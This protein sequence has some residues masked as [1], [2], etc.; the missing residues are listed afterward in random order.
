MAYTR[1]EAS[2]VK[3]E[4]WKKYGQF[5]APVPSADWE[6]PKV[7]WI[8]YKT[9]IKSIHFK[10]N[11]DKRTASIG[12]YIISDEDTQL[13]IYTLMDKFLQKESDFEDWEWEIQEHD[14][15]FGT[16][17]KFWIEIDDV[18][19][20]MPEKWPKLISF[21]KENMIKLDAFWSNYKFA[22]DEF[23]YR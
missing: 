18:N 23:K 20:F 14:N 11:A 6:Q 19:I 7:N 10:M 5:M 16:V 4:F 13:E 12:I 15:I 17:T 21:F 2:R 22:F 9:G 1:E 3:T 8:N